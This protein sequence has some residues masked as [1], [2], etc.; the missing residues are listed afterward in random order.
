MT[1]FNFTEGTEPMAT[2]A[3][4][5]L[6]PETAPTDIVVAVQKNPGLVLL[7]TEK[8]DAFYDRLK[9]K[10]PADADVATKKGRDAL[11]SFAA[12][13]RSEKASINKARLSLTKEW[14]DMVDQANAAGKVIDQRLEGL[15]VEVRA[16]LTAWEEAEKA[17]V[18]RGNALVASLKAAATVTLDDTAATVRERGNEVF[19]TAIDADDIG[20]DLFAEASAV[21]QATIQ[22][23]TTALARLT[24]EEAERAELEQLRAAQA[25]REAEEAARREEQER[26]EGRR[27]YARDVIEHIR[28]C[29]LG[30]IGGKTYPYIILI[31]ELEEKVVVSEA[32]FGDMA[33]E[34]EKARVETLAHIREAFERQMER[35]RQEAAEQAAREAREAEARKAEEAA[36]AMQREHAEQLAAERRRAEQAERDAQAERDRVAAAEAAR[37]AEAQRIADEQAKREADIAH[38]TAVKSRAKAAIMSCGADEETAKKIVVA[39]LAGEIP[40]VR[41]EF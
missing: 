6:P 40:A 16:P 33:G 22:A 9:A 4:E 36:A 3:A 25:E 18:E 7:D 20:D 37:A 34:V 1:E 41:L 15:A 5:V 28:Q 27:Q 30:M 39:I 17:R 12:E 35:S 29:G 19:N 32:D 2:A 38:R 23:L 31:R 26:I 21:K 10:A 8:F 24:R 13:V 14:R 11:R